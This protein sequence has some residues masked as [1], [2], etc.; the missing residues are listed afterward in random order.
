MVLPF[1]LLQLAQHVLPLSLF[2]GTALAA[3]S[4]FNVKSHGTGWRYATT[5]SSG[6]SGDVISTGDDL[7]VSII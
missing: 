2:A 5:A 4:A 3:N 1:P 7:T 6:D